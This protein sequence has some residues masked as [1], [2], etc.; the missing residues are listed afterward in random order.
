VS[1]TEGRHRGIEVLRDIGR[2]RPPGWGGQRFVAEL[3][4]CVEKASR[5]LDRRPSRQRP[6]EGSCDEQEPSKDENER[7]TQRCTYGMYRQ[8]LLFGLAGS[9]PRVVSVRLRNPSRSRSS[10]LR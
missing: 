2:L 6:Y 3:D 7:A 8:L 10:A 1:R 5:L 4:R 9:V